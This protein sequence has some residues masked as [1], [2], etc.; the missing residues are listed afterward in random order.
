MIV[1]CVRTQYQYGALDRTYCTVPADD[2]LD[3]NWCC[4]CCCCSSVVFWGIE[5]VEGAED[6]LSLSASIEFNDMPMLIVE[7]EFPAAL[8]ASGVCN[9]ESEWVRS[10]SI[11]K[12]ASLILSSSSPFSSSTPPLP[13]TTSFLRPFVD[14]KDASSIS[15]ESMRGFETASLPVL[16]RK[17]SL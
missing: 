9:N 12:C 16:I 1:R 5:I 15:R 3:C 6:V 10:Q 13:L 4:C 8:R 17:L 11:S 2:F 14:E 7:V